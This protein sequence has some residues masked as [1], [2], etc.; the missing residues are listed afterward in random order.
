MTFDGPLLTIE[1]SAE[2]ATCVDTDASSFAGS[3][4]GVALDTEALLTRVVDPVG[5]VTTTVI[6]GATSPAAS[7]GRTQDTEALPDA[8]HVQPVPSAETNVTPAGSVS[9]TATSTA[10]DGPLLVAVSR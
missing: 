3:G 5:A 6:V 9:V 10:S 7:A 1:R 4:S 2:P 8:V